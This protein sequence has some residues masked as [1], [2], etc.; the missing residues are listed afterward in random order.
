MNDAAT[1]DG[2]T[3]AI[4]RSSQTEVFA[5]DPQQRLVGI[6][7]NRYGLAVQIENDLSHDAPFTSDTR[8]PCQSTL[9]LFGQTPRG[10]SAARYALRQDSIPTRRV[11][12]GLCVELTVLASFRRSF[13]CPIIVCTTVQ[14]LASRKPSA[15][16]REANAIVARCDATDLQLHF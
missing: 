15:S 2:H 10:R 11:G 13:S 16:P 6:G 14:T 8:G 3:A 9:L 7:V 5:Q 4:L 1:A 12:R